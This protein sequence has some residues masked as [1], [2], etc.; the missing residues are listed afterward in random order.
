MFRESSMELDRSEIGPLVNNSINSQDRT[1]KTP[2]EE[3][4]FARVDQTS[5]KLEKASQL[6]TYI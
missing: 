6:I 3:N 1:V 2:L 5:E 4:I